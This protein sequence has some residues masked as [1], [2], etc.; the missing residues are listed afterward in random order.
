MRQVIFVIIAFACS[1]SSNELA[2]PYSLAILFAARLQKVWMCVMKIHSCRSLAPLETP[3]CAFKGG[4]WVY[5]KS[6]VLVHI[7]DV[8]D[9]MWGIGVCERTWDDLNLGRLGLV[10]VWVGS[11]DEATPYPKP[12]LHQ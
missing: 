8:C 2:Y 9:V 10:V 4:F 1:H 5:A 6:T 11:T 7:Y 12:Y 3:A